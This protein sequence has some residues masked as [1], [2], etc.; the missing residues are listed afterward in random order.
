MQIDT[1]LAGLPVF[2]MRVLIAEDEPFHCE[3]LQRMLNVLGF[4]D[5]AA[6]ANGQQA[7]DIAS[8][9]P[10]HLIIT[11]MEMPEMDGIRLT[12]ELRKMN[13]LTQIPIIM[14]TSHRNAESIVKAKQAGVSHYI[15]KPFDIVTLRDRIMQAYADKSPN[16][17]GENQLKAAKKAIH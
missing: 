13:D 7:L 4:R 1:Y 15:G 14:L 11:D 12:G 16:I 17:F 6:A 3:V 2:G 5:V 8:K 9:D 10:F